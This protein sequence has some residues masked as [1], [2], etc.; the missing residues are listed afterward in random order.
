[1]KPTNVHA[2]WGGTVLVFLVHGLLVSTW[3]SRIP[4]IKAGLGLNDAELGLALLSTA[5]GAVGAIP[6]AG[7]FVSRY[8]SRRVTAISSMALCL[9]LV[10]P[11]LA[12][13]LLSLAAAL[14]AFGATAASM[15][16]S[17]NAQGVEVEKRLGKPTMSRFHGMFSLGAMVG[18]GVG[19]MV[20][21]RSIRPAI[22]FGVSAL[23]Y[24]V[25]IIVI[26][27][28]L[29][30]THD[31]VQ[32]EE[33]AISLK[34]IPRAL[35]ALSAIGFCILLSEGAMADWTAVYLR[36]VLNAGS[37]T[38]AAG[39]SVFSA[40]MATFRF[41]GDLITS[42]LGP[43]R[44]VR[45][46][47]LVAAC[48]MIWA[49]SVRSAGWSMPGFAAAGAGFSVIIPLVFGGGGSVQS[50]SPG[51]GIATVT[52]IGYIGFIVGPPAIG[53]VAQIFTLRYALGLVVVCCIIASLLSGFIG[54]LQRSS[55]APMMTEVQA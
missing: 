13:S 15:D 54:R 26:A 35:L 18:A 5:I 43:A 52:G 48:G 50:I 34:R 2:A 23:V 33:G 40:A 44:T 16:V 20:A 31:G 10:L 37:G 30:E 12:V 55:E 51:A 49:L 27:P 7:R 8:G 1:M 53:F 39:Y 11:G 19:G 38:A 25:A 41:L 14:F 24:L 9:S 22:H 4:A 17:M 32:P 47:G 36:Q 45:T 29:L 46:G 42:R 28:L 6:F 21:A 3:I